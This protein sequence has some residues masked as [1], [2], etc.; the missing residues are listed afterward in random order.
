MTGNEDKEEENIS[1]PALALL[2]KMKSL[3]LATIGENNEPAI[4]YTPFIM[5]KQRVYILISALAA[6]TQHLANRPQ[7]ALLIIE[8]EQDCQNIFAR[9]RLA[10]ECD[11]HFVERTHQQ[12]NDRLDLFTERHGNTVALLK[13]LPD[14]SLV[15]LTPKYGNYIQGFGQAYRFNGLALDKAQQASAPIAK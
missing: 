10:L 5:H 4:S 1:I 6:H 8:D 15:E 9:K 3:Q 12:W 13:K 11:A 7:A 2:D 14:F